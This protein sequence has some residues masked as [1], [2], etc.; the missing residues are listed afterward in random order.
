MGEA[1]ERDKHGIVRRDEA[2]QVVD[3]QEEGWVKGARSGANRGLRRRRE[4][5]P[6][7]NEADNDGG[8]SIRREPTLAIMEAKQR[9]H[10][11]A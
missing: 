6:T 2:L 11:L 3:Q 10:D 7:R 8:S 1:L 9:S 5:H 4:L